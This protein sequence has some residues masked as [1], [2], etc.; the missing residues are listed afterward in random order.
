MSYHAELVL[1]TFLWW[2]AWAMIIRTLIHFLLYNEA[3]LVRV[4]GV[5]CGG[6]LTNIFNQAIMDKA[7]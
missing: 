3:G 6:A 2:G 7:Q 5:N 1:D 4:R